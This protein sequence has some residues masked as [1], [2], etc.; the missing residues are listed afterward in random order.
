[1]VSALES[2]SRALSSPEAGLLLV[3]TKISGPM[4]RSI[5]GLCVTL[6]MVRV[7]SDNAREHE[8]ITLR[9][10]RELDL[11]RGRDSWC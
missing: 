8:T 7:K 6:R 9:I 4:G 10:F 1:M 11:P 2:E 3:S 5:H